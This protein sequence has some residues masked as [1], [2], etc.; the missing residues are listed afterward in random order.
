[1]HTPNRSYESNINRLLRFLLFITCSILLLNCTGTDQTGDQ[2]AVSQIIPYQEGDRIVWDYQTLKNISGPRHAFYPRMITTSNGE[3][4]TVYES[5]GNIYLTRSADDGNSWSESDIIAN[6]NGTVHATVPEIIEL[7][8]GNLMVAYNTRPPQENTDENLR[9]GIKGIISS[10][11]GVH[12]SDPIHIYKGGFEWNRG[13][14]EPVMIE[15]NDELLLFFAN[16]HPYVDNNDQEIS[17]VKSADNGLNWSPPQTVSYR[18]GHRDGMP[19]P[20][21]LKNSDSL[22]I[23]IEDNGFSGTEFKPVIIGFSD[24]KDLGSKVV[25]GDS[26]KRWGALN[27][28]NALD[29]NEYG[30]AP[31]IVELPSGNLLLSF[32]STKNRDVPWNLSTMN[33]AIGDQN[34]ENFSHITEPF[35]VGTSQPALWGSLHVKNDSTVTALTSTD[36]Y[37]EDGRRE[38]YAIDGY[39][40]SHIGIPRGTLQSSASSFEESDFSKIAGIG[41]YTPVFAEL[42]AMQDSDFLHVGVDIKN[43]EKHAFT[44]GSYQFESMR[45]MIASGRLQE[46]ALSAGVYSVTFSY[47]GVVGSFKGE[48]GAWT[49]FESE[50]SLKMITNDDH[51]TKAII[52]I[53]LSEIGVRSDSEDAFGVNASLQVREVS[54][55]QL[56]DEVLGG[57]HEVRPFTWN[58]AVISD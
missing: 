10:D 39:I 38:I 22:L 20:I 18:E 25:T 29:D 52:S 44:N 4:I 9:F 45:F 49:D 33:V 32:Q 1:M 37:N 43:G 51:T 41:A 46:D 23:A 24:W 12:W 17:F 15:L 16:E 27:E 36:A 54:T 50:M 40:L 34:G 48:K 31:Y 47:D 53:P 28:E 56:I 6:R 7:Q 30:G 2:E 58:K 19:V 21:K 55:N 3:R 11:N 5:E 14:W 57:N 26:D 8:N 42:Y 35:L 13:V